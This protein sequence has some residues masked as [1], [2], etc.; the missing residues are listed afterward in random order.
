MRRLRTHNAPA[1]EELATVAADEGLPLRVVEIDVD[2]ERSVDA[3]VRHAV[4][5]T[6]G[7]LDVLVNN[8]GFATRGPVELLPPDVVEAMYRTNVLGP[9]RMARAVLPVMR[10]NGAGLLVQMSSG[11]GRIGFPLLGAYASTKWAL[12]GLSATLRYELAPLGIDVCIVE[13]APYPTRFRE[14]YNANWEAFVRRASAADRARFPDYADH[15]R[16]YDAAAAVSPASDPQQVVDTV[17]RLAAAPAGSR[18]MRTVV[19]P[20]AETTALNQLNGVSEQL[21]RAFT[22]ARG[23]GDWLDLEV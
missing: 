3:G 21:E 23:F 14:T 16:R 13:P 12:E 4:R 1:A 2:L 11:V 18:P 15:L 6:G 20:P 10:G 22:A 5:L 8:A 7:R 17:L 9:H 19:A